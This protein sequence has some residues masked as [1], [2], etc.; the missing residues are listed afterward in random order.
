ME[1]DIRFEVWMGINPEKIYLTLISQ[2]H[3]F[4]T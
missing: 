4:G 2:Y 3:S 1:D